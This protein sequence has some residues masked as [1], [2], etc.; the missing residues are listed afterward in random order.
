MIRDFT[1]SAPNEEDLL[2]TVRSSI[3]AYPLRLWAGAKDTVG[4][5]KDFLGE[6]LE[7]FMDEMTVLVSPSY[8]YPLAEGMRLG[9]LL[10]EHRHLLLLVHEGGQGPENEG[11]NKDGWWSQEVPER[12]LGQSQEGALVLDFRYLA[13]ESVKRVRSW[14]YQE[15]DVEEIWLLGTH[16][17]VMEILYAVAEDVLSLI[18]LRRVVIE[19]PHRIGYRVPLKSVG[20]AESFRR[21]GE[22]SR[23]QRHGLLYLYQHWMMDQYRSPE[24]MEIWVDGGLLEG[25]EEPSRFMT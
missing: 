23:L 5:L 13:E 21:K 25:V 8:P 11:E 9:A 2:I 17:L 10:V 18:R 24:E 16:P 12:Y 22:E 19:S 6:R 7:R 15:R 4:D 1:D 3:D 14:L 20:R